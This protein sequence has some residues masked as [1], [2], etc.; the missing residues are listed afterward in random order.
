MSNY[1]WTEEEK[2]FIKDNAHRLKDEEMAAELTKRFG[3]K[4]SFS[5]TRKQR[6]RMK[7]KKS[8]GKGVCR[9]EQERK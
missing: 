7:I 5:G 1:K 3:R 9:V 4:V 6:Q 8:G 2:S